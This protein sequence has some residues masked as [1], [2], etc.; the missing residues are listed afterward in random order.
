METVPQNSEK[1]PEFHLTVHKIPFYQSGI[2]SFIFSILENVRCTL[3][4]TV[5]NHLPRLQVLW[6]VRAPPCSLC[7]NYTVTTYSSKP[8]D[9]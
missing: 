6:Q 8:D 2:V 3:I 5:N 9:S 7:N 4:H 1:F